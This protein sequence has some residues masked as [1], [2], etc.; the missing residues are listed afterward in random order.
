MMNLAMKLAQQ[1]FSKTVL[2]SDRQPPVLAVKT[3]LKAGYYFSIT[4]SFGAE[5]YPVVSEDASLQ[6]ATSTSTTV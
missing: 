4:I 5:D 3:D 1:N 6:A 2:E